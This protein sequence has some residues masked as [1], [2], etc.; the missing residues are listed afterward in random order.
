MSALNTVRLVVNSEEYAGWKEVSIT[1]GIERQARD[2]SL[3]VTDRWPGQQAIPRRVRPGDVCEIYIGAD[4][5]LTGYVDATPINY[6][7]KR[8][9]VGVRGRSKT[10]DLIDCS[11]INE[12]G[13]WR[14][15]KLERIAQDL[16]APYGI[17]VTSE[18][19]TG[20]P[21][22]DHQI[23]QGETVF[24]SIDRLLRQRYLLAT[25]D[26]EG[27]LVFI[28]VGRQR[29]TTALVLGENLL[30]GSSD[31]DHKDR[32]SR[33]VAKG[34]RPPLEGDDPE[35]T[36][37]ESASIDDAGVTRPRVLV[38]KQ[39]GQAD[40]GTCRDRVAYERAHRAAKSLAATYTVQGWRQGDG[41]LW[42]PNLLVRVRDALIGFDSELLISE[43]EY[44]LNDN[45]MVC[46]LKVGPRDGFLAK[47]KKKNT[48]LE[49]WGDVK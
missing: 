6:E 20:A 31:L 4:K 22:L 47:P 2:F 30:T 46:E 34:Q 24:E 1:A 44:R 32:Y 48:E 19:D 49:S 28:D 13:Q 11:A 3:S 7:A 21:I 35:D 18:T 10:A 43:V 27:A 40:E 23:E 41:D 9:S 16:A 26:E 8:I 36:S 45:G 39:T 42:R 5:V 37:Q 14:G 38:V 29:A 15:Q 17:T 33:Y 25:D 12:P